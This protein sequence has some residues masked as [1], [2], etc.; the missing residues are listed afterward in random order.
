MTIEIFD[1]NKDANIVYESYSLSAVELLRGPTPDLPALDDWRFALVMRIDEVAVGYIEVTYH[2]GISDAYI[3][4]LYVSP[5]HRRKRIA[6]LLLAAAEARS[7]FYWNLRRF[8]A[9]TVDNTA[10][11]KLF[12]AAG[13]TSHGTLKDSNYSKGSYKS[14][15]MWSKARQ[16]SVKPDLSQ[17]EQCIDPELHIRRGEQECNGSCQLDTKRF[18]Q[19]E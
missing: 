18:E 7:T 2:A 13:Y 4:Y 3:L 14:K 9:D 19:H 10:A 12:K 15:T 8:T 5:N 17:F 1:K 6:S 11:E 16:D